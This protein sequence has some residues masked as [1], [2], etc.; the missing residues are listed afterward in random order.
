MASGKRRETSSEFR[1]PST[2]ANFCLVQRQHCFI[3]SQEQCVSAA[4]REELYLGIGLALVGLKAHRQL[5]VSR[6]QPRTRSRI[7]RNAG[8]DPACARISGFGEAQ[9]YGRLWKV[10]RSVFARSE[11]HTSEL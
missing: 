2:A 4:S 5:A 10:A 7:R 1:F 8:C 6:V 11:E 9:C 3:A